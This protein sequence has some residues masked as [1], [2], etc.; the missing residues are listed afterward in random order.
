MMS[1]MSGIKVISPFQ[2]LDLSCYFAGLYPALVY[3]RPFR[4]LCVKY[5]KGGV[6]TN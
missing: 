4:A 6:V 5:N 2:G 3:H 1:G